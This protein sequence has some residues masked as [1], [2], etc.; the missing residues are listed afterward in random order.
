VIFGDR[1]LIELSKEEL[2]AVFAHEFAHIKNHHHILR[3]IAFIGLMLTGYIAF[4]KLP[5]IILWYAIFALLSMA[6]IPINWYFEFQADEYAK[7]YVGPSY[8]AS[9]LLKLSK[10]HNMDEGSESHPPTNRRIRLLHE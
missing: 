3:Q 5:D 4:I 9:A 2:L 7:K 1:M 10:D 6:M 8:L